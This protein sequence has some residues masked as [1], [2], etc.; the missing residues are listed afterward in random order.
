ML[1]FM[2]KTTS[3]KITVWS[4][5]RKLFSNLSLCIHNIS[6]LDLTL[7]TGIFLGGSFRAL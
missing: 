3:Y 5:I 1:D 7:F 4:D 6:A 2:A